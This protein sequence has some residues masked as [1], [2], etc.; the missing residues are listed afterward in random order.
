V[1]VE[2]AVLGS[3]RAWSCWSCRSSSRSVASSGMNAVG[4]ERGKYQPEICGACTLYA[5]VLRGTT[6]VTHLLVDRGRTGGH[7][8]ADGLAHSI[9]TGLVVPA[10]SCVSLLRHV[11]RAR[12]A[13]AVSLDDVGA[14]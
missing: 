7:H 9:E 2:L 5:R 13:R 10:W 8:A 14:A 6:G 3:A 11:V 1:P 12:S 4:E